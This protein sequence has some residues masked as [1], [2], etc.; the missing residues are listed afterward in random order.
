MTQG[1]AHESVV[2]PWASTTASPLLDVSVCEA[3]RRPQGRCVTQSAEGAAGSICELRQRPHKRCQPPGVDPGQP[4]LT[5]RK[6]PQLKQAGVRWFPHDLDIKPI[7]MKRKR[8][9]MT[10]E[11]NN[12]NK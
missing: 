5:C 3:G 2:R 10:H 1:G 12:C 9:P 7:A 8:M 4:A 6:Q 11:I